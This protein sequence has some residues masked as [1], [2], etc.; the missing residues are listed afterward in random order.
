[1]KSSGI[2]PGGCRRLL[3][4]SLWILHG[5]LLGRNMKFAQNI[6]LSGVQ[7]FLLRYLS[8]IGDFENK[9]FLLEKFLSGIRKVMG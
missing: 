7:E 4:I 9:D 2:N 6:S 3:E 5:I 8:S 1:M